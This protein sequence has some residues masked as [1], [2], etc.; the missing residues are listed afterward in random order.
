ML[1]DGLYALRLGLK[2]EVMRL[3]E[4]TCRWVDP[5]TVKLLPLWYP[6]HARRSYFYKSVETNASRGLPAML[7]RAVAPSNQ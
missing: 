1:P 7:G 2:A 4:R 5:D 3:I 6:E